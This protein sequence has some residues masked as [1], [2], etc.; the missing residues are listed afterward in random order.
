MKIVIKE[1]TLVCPSEQTPRRRLWLS[2]VDLLFTNRGYIPTLFF[3]KFNGSPNFFDPRVLKES[4]SR[5][6]VPFY[7]VAGRLARD[8]NNRIE[9]DCNGQGVSYAEAVADSAMP[10]IDNFTATQE[11]VKVIPPINR[12][13]D[14][15]YSSPL[16][17]V[18]VTRFSCGGVSLG[19]ASH[20]NLG[21]GTGFLHFFTSWSELARGLSVSISPFLDR[22]ILRARIPPTP[23]FHHHEFDK[24]PVT[25]P[26]LTQNLKQSSGSK[27]N[28]S[29]IV[30]ITSDHMKTLTTMV[31]NER[32]KIKYTRYE[33][34]TAFLWRVATE[35]RNLP[36]TQPTKIRIP[37]D[38]RSRLNPPLPPTYFGNVIFICATTALCGE[39]LKE[40]LV[41]TVDRIHEAIMRMDDK[42]LR[43]ALDFLDQTD[44][45]TSIMHGPQNSAC[46]NFNVVSWTSL[47]FHGVD[48]GWGQG[49]IRPACIYEGKG[50]IL[51]SSTNKGSLLF[52]MCLETEHI[53]AFREIFRASFQR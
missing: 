10:D 38:G 7:P 48:F 31:G 18:Q 26:S 2:A 40:P 45:L 27:T 21:D 35:A 51:A 46:P 34:L 3:Y 44:D 52:A 4:L 22:T 17:A 5:V 14:D 25:V 6:L 8:G 42:Y 9:I 30:D 13:L 43:S 1:S 50:Y 37:V 33:I 39:L 20:H 53:Q 49:Y 11:L 15:L 16:F 24:P 32:S 19:I 36:E 12:S 29:I 41:H 47:P 28:S 23:E